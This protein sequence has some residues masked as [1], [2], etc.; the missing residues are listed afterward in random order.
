MATFLNL[1]GLHQLH[2]QKFPSSNSCFFNRQ[3]APGPRERPARQR[4][5]KKTKGHHLACKT[6][7]NPHN[8][9]GNTTTQHLIR[10]RIQ[11]KKNYGYTKRILRVY[12]DINPRSRLISIASTHAEATDSYVQRNYGHLA[13]R[14][15]R[16]QPSECCIWLYQTILGD[17]DV[18][19]LIWAVARD[20][21]ILLSALFSSIQQFVLL[22]LNQV[23]LSRPPRVKI[24]S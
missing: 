16:K 19:T 11:A 14:S 1:V 20:G 2:H 8:T 17:Y 10:L 18:I 12:S 5:D 7:A 13:S 23:N 9:S 6:V 22:R 21:N 3:P 24:A 4:N 15:E